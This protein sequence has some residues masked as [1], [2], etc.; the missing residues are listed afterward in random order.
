MKKRAVFLDRDGVLIHEVDYLSDPRKLKLIDGAAQ[1]VARLRCAGYKV[2]VVSNQ[3]GV[4]RGMFSLDRLQ[5]VHRR[6]RAELKA[7]GARLDG[8]Y[9]CPHH[10][11]APL[12]RYRRNCLCRKPFP[13]M[14]RQ[15]VR[16]FK[17]SIAHCYM[18]GDSTV[19]LEA[20]LR[21]GC[22]PLLVRTGKGGRD[23]VHPVRPEKVFADLPAAA[24]WILSRP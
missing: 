8:L 7:Q 13:G 14:L 12:A 16:R 5:Q 24:A 15:A 9:F 1:A 6:L 3:S 18:V 23:G 4:A 17:L 11:E 19:D 2:I 10:P 20:A 21:A 22:R